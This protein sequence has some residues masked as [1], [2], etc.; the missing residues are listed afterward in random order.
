[1]LVAI[2]AMASFVACD[3]DLKY[4]A[5]F[6]RFEVDNLT[7]EAGDESVNLSWAS[8]AGKPEPI[9][10]FITWTS[11]SAD[12][13]GGK[14]TLP[15]EKRVTV[16][17]G[18]I[19]DNTY[20]FG[21]QARY[22]EG[23]AHKVTVKCTPKSTRI[24]VS[25]FK[26]M[27]GDKRA[28]ASWTKPKT[29]LPYSYKLEVS[30]N[31]DV[32]KTV[33]PK[34]DASAC[35]IEGLANGVEYRFTMI[36]VYGHGN[37]TLCSAIATPGEISPM[38]FLP[39]QP[40]PYELTKIE[41]NPA[42]FVMGEIA[43]VEWTFEDGNKQDT[44]IATYTFP[45]G[46]SK[47]TLTVTYTDGQSESAS[48]VVNVLPFAWSDLDGTG[49]QKS[50]SMVF[51]PDGQQM[52]TIS[53][54]T[55]TVFGI[56]AIT[57]AILWQYAT[58]AATYGAGPAVAKNGSI[59]FGTE[60]GDGSVFALSPNGTLCWVA[61][62]GNSIKAAPAVTS[63]GVVY[64]LADGGKL[65]ALDLETGAEKWSAQGSGNA[66]GV[67]VDKDGTIYFGTSEGVWAYNANGSMKWKS[68][69]AHKVTARG[70]NVVISDDYILATLAGKGG[71]V[72]IDK[73]TG[74][75]KWQYKTTYGDCYNPVVDA[76]GTV[77]FNEKAGGLYAV[78]KDGSLKWSYTTDL[79]YTF[80]G[81]ALGNDGQAYISQYAAPFNLLAFSENGIPTII[82]NIGVQTMSPVTIGP[83][84]RIYYGKN[85]SIS[86]FN[87][88]VGLAKAQWPC[89]GANNQATN[90]LK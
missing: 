54:N 41:Y 42:Y 50:S 22:P 61:K 15:A 82:T 49:Y 35:L 16:I 84:R 77:Y 27:A 48:M 44:P 88:G 89:R 70:G 29:D 31:G 1:M 30:A 51:S 79:N 39:A 13:S 58:D 9:E 12:I 90:S 67:A 36:C 5:D 85:G 72:A 78:K 73:A 65:A 45:S 37:S 64:A 63:D 14:L 26:V 33:T 40:H 6:N 18:L 3:D 2:L 10:Y 7:I 20:T 86:V 4:K 74:A 75:T 80:S 69:N 83:D 59:I 52:Y 43:F 66:G 53:Q 19:N 76:E 87:A 46:T 60:D 62:L 55:K 28:Y 8:Q 68:A 11:T 71:V 24:P 38:S 34:S 81:F 25:N 56:N 32:I 57:G 21:V 23:L 17:T 47:I